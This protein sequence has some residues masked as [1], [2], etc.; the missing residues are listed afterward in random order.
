MFCEK[1]HRPAAPL[2]GEGD[3]SVVGGEVDEEGQYTYSR[4]MSGWGNRLEGEGSSRRRMSIGRMG[5]R[6]R[7]AV[8]G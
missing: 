1:S 4:K 6:G 8:K 2:K 7:G 3:W 5:R